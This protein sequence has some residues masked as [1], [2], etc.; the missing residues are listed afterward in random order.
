[1][2]GGRR[3]LCRFFFA[4][5]VIATVW[6]AIVTATGG[7]VIGHGMTRFRARS[8]QPPLRVAIVSAVAVWALL[9]GSRRREALHDEWRTTV[10]L[11]ARTPAYVR[12]IG[13]TLVPVAAGGIAAAV[14]AVAVLKGAFVAGGSDSYSYLSQAELWLSGT[15][16]VEQPLVRE[17]EWPFADKAFAPFGYVSV[18]RTTIVPITPPGF[19]ILMAAFQRI[20][21]RQAVFYVV[22][23]LGGLAIWATYLIGRRIAGPGIGLGA[24][25]LMATSPTFLFQLMFPMS[26]VPAMAWWALALALVLCES[27]GAAL[28]AGVSAGLAILT[29]PNL[30]PV[31]VVPALY[32]LSGALHERQ[33]RGTAVTRA[34]L[35]TAGAVPF[36]VGVA[37]FNTFLYGSPLASGYGNLAGLF[38][39][40]N[41]RANLSQYP[42]WLLETQTPAVLIACAVPFV[43]RSFAARRATLL[44]LLFIAAV[45]GCHLL[46][47][48]FD[49]WWYL[50]YLLPA[51]PPM[52]ALTAIGLAALATRLPRRLRGIVTAGAILILAVRG[53]RQAADL[54][55]FDVQEGQR[56]YVAIGDYVARRL[57]ERAIIISAMHSG[58]IR[59]YSGRPTVLWLWI[60]ETRL[61]SIVDQFRGLGF[62]PY[63]VLES[64]EEAEFR[65][66]FQDASDLAAL[67]WPPMASLRSEE[68]RI[69]D[70]ADRL[71][72][73]AG[74]RVSPEIID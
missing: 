58:S 74:G 34:A 30:V 43:A 38:E 48:P 53:V 6:A 9:P 26:D 72:A 4:L 49:A 11:V 45:W 21:G 16:R 24:A 47:K 1:M 5:A 40:A 19:P 28:A 3:R 2:S 44:C 41:L 55:V 33:W 69:Y 37:V 8:P 50:R 12:H 56:K 62:H 23:L 42:R 13:P 32:L 64:T 73:H 68:T 36:C 10:R 15:L 59:Y 60:P 54:W 14:V 7:I 31:A 25:A 39:W 65:Q 70:P 17:L 51:F 27:R 22:P 66:R 52:F 67:D 71:A 29:R 46:L 18:D 63:F 20:G 35:F 61:D 57:P